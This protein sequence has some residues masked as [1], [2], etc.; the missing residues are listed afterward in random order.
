[1]HID[2]KSKMNI[3]S[4]KHDIYETKIFFLYPQSIIQNQLIKEIVK[5]E[6]AAYIINDHEK[7]LALLEKYQ[8]SIIFINIDAVLQDDQWKIYIKN[9]QNS[10]RFVNIRTG[11]LSHFNDEK[12]EEYYLMELLIPCGFIKMKSN[13]EESLKIILK[14]LDANEAR[15][16]RKY[17]RVKCDKMDNVSCS[18]KLNS[19]IYKGTIVDISSAGM[20]FMLQGDGTY[21][22]EST[23][24][25][26]IQLLLKGK[27]C[28]LSGIIKG[29][30][31]TEGKKIYVLL[32]DK[33]N[34]DESD[35]IHDFIFQ[36]LQD[37]ITK[38]LEGI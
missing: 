31:Q 7:A 13:F 33:T 28:H 23:E 22:K 25:D 35:K 4:H 9:I 17:V 30:R 29:E 16:K 38:E 15:G 37:E 36:A 34:H 20:A 11:I 32:F 27:L 1:M 3:E 5:N 12:K 6:Y 21:F 10:P 8:D 2:M 24:I 26:N 18:I 19:V 14:V